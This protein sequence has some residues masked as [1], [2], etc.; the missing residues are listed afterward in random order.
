[1]VSN[2]RPKRVFASLVVVSAVAL[3]APAPFARGQSTE[4]SSAGSAGV[5]AVS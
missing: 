5:A 4:G 3:F 2:V 1:M